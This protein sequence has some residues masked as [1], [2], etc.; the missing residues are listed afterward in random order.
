MFGGEGL[1]GDIRRIEGDL[2]GGVG[3]GMG[4]PGEM[5]GGMGYPGGMGGG[6][7]GEVRRAEED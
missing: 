5:G 2:T 6:I 4:Y 3:G 7:G 1:G